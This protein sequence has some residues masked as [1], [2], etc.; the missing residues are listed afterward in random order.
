LTGESGIASAGTGVR[1]QSNDEAATLFGEEAPELN[2]FAATQGA[3]DS[4]L[5]LLWSFADGSGKRVLDAIRKRKI[6]RRLAVLSADVDRQRYEEVYDAFRTYRL[7]RNHEALEKQRENWERD[8]RR[9]IEERCRKDT[10][11]VA[12]YK[13]IDDVEVAMKQLEA[14]VPLI[15]VDVPV[16]ATARVREEK[17]SL[18]YLEERA[19]SGAKAPK[20][21]SFDFKHASIDLGQKAFD[22]SVGKIRVFVAPEWRDLFAHLLSPEEV[23]G[24]ITA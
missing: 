18:W 15:L 3:D 23:I 5:R 6:Y 2:E 17:G 1:T 16:K 10:G 11:A 9:T 4:I 12:A 19:R 20:D 8:I 13:G 24:V 22:L 21:L 14:T 7:D